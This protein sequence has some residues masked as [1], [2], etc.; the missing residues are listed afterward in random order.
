M[1]NATNIL[2]RRE[3]LSDVTL[4]PVS[5]LS[6]NGKTTVVF[7]EL[8]TS[9]PDAALITMTLS[10]EV[11]KTGVRKNTRTLMVPVMEIIPSGAVNSDGR[12]AAPK[13][14]HYETDVRT[15]Y[16]SPRS[17]PTERADS[18]RMANHV[19]V[20]AA[21]T[22]AQGSAPWGST[23]NSYRDLTSTYQAPYA[24]IYSVWPSA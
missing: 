19:D 4:V 14:S 17:N 1:P 15:R 11:L 5:S 23:A 6:E 2:V 7:R 13:V 10:T 12:T 8:S 16:H 9:K 22:A 24:D 21:A 3:D 18:L 20:G